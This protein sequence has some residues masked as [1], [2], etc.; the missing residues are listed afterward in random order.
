MRLIQAS[1]ITETV[2]RLCV[3]AAIEVEEP[4][5][6]ALR[7]ALRR[8]NSPIA[9]EVLRQLLLNAKIAREERLPICQDTGLAVIFVR[10]G[11]S[12]RISGG[13]LMTAINRGVARGYRDGYLRKSVVE[14]PLRRVNTG[15]NTPAIVHIELVRGNKVE[16][17]VLLKG[18]GCENMSRVAMLAPAEGQDGIKRFVIETVRE[19]GAKSCPPLIVGV[20]MG[21]DLELCALLAKKAL[22]RP[23]RSRNADRRLARL[24]RELLTEINRLGI[25][26]AGLGGD[27]TALAVHIEAHPCHI[28]S[29]PVAV[30]LDCHAHRYR[31]A[32]L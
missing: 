27:T 28:A 17:G 2:A 11:S 13:H 7:A 23:L 22:T 16:I 1:L 19:G 10:L 15:D 24:E 32:T 14:S 9:R 3:E 8:E 6:N 29:L 12:V 26:P 5:I 21:G 31:S 25:G 20:G 30:N 18:G 4:L